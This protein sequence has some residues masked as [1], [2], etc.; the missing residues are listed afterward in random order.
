M[1]LKRRLKISKF[2]ILSVVSIALASCSRGGGFSLSKK[3][4]EKSLDT[5]LTLLKKKKHDQAIKCLEA[6]KSRNFGKSNVA[7]A[8]LAI[9]DSYFNNKEYLVAAEAY[10]VFLESY[11]Y[12]EK[13]PYAHLRR[14]MSYLKEIPKGVDR[15][16]SYLDN[17]LNS[18]GK[19][20]KYYGN[21]PYG[22]QG[23]ELYKL[24]KFKKA[25]QNFYVGRFYFRMKEYLA[26]I[27]R[28]ETIVTEFTGL[29]LDDKSFYYL[30]KALKETNQRELAMR[31]FEVYKKIY[32][33]R[34]KT[35]K[36]IAR[37]F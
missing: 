8:D 13:V 36:K 26:A 27:P 28:F 5:C 2:I 20:A 16:Q 34:M 24:A 12:H 33:N 32:P 30:I 11:P 3:S 35:I 23:R 37:I 9:A 10:G 15:D 22:A 21:T 14:G 6:Y 18:L 31:Y 7:Y 19:V 1:K 17:A 4:G 29:G 25:K